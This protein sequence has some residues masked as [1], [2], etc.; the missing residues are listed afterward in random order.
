LTGEAGWLD[1]P[2]TIRAILASAKNSGKVTDAMR[3]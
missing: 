2:P 3:A 1:L